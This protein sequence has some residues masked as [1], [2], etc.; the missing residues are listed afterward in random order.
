MA[1]RLLIEVIEDGVGKEPVPIEEI[2]R[3]SLA[4]I[5]AYALRPAMRALQTWS[6]HVAGWGGVSAARKPSTTTFR[7]CRP[8]IIRTIRL[9]R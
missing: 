3:L 2:A 8:G 1:L 7:P 5:V 4:L 6:A 9:V